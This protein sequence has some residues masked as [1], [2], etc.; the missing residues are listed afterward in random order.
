MLSRP[1]A[2]FWGIFWIDASSNQNAEAGF[3]YLGGLVKKN[4]T[5]E[6]GKHWLSN[7][8]KPW[9]LVIDNADDPEMDVSQYFPSGGRG[10]ILITTRN[11]NNVVHS[12]IGDINF[13]EM[14]QED[15]IT[16]LLKAA[17]QPDHTDLQ[18]REIARPIA[19][20][21]GHLALALTHAGA[22][23][24]R[25]I[26]TLEGYLPEYY[27][28][29]KEM[30]KH[31]ILR[32]ADSYKLNIVTTWEV[33]YERIKQ[34]NTT[35][36]M[37][38]IEILH[39][40]AFLHFEQ[41]PMI[42]FQK[43]WSNTRNPYASLPSKPGFFRVIWPAIADTK[44]P[45]LPAILRQSGPVWDQ[46]RFNEALNQLSDYSLI[47]RDD[48]KKLCSM[49]PVVHAWAR[50]RLRPDEQRHWL[51]AAAATLANSIT[52]ELECSGRAYR[53]SLIPHVDSCLQGKN[54]E[55]LGYHKDNVQASNAI[56]FASLYAENGHWVIARG[57]QRKVLQLWKESLGPDHPETLR[58][59]AALGQTCWN[60]SQMKE[61][62]EV[63]SNVYSTRERTL[64]MANPET[65]KA[66][67]DL[68]GTYW[69]VGE[70]KKSQDLA[71]QAMDGLRKALGPVDSATLTAMQ[72]LGRIYLHLGQPS[73]AQTL[74]SQVLSSRQRFFGAKHPDTLITMTDLAMAYLALNRL[75]EAER[76]TTET[77]KTRADTLGKEHPYT[78]W[79]SNDL[80]KIYCA[81][82]RTAEAIKFLESILPIAHR[83]L[84]PTHIGMSMTKFNLARAY[85]SQ[86]CWSNAER[87]LQEQLEILENSKHPDWVHSMAELGKVFWRG[88]RDLENA[89]RCYV[90][91][92]EVVV[93]TRA[94]GTEHPTVK[95]IVGGLSE[96]YKE[97]GR[98]EEIRELEAKIALLNVS[99]N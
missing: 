26:Y 28:H 94:L 48:K 93:E 14:E 67:N 82:Q 90:E 41:I 52:P 73:E 83:T 51:A 50:D 36:A 49:H 70:R 9:L 54:A 11:P 40:F 43:A 8:L 6:A 55:L 65:L 31:D 53:R 42:M 30:M 29:R 15:A 66:M 45:P 25:N 60:L 75:P 69:L 10:H 79:S 47:D 97:Q 44:E 46:S 17:N 81:Q 56:K 86:K 77:L 3:A 87:T 92:L 33:P 98:V 59:M 88:K 57:I 4:E 39:I 35:I 13:R 19:N 61:A 34:R 89:E 32:N 7:R 84:G 63:Q 72:T 2:S 96:V 68:A 22:T 99:P 27:E 20:A 91:A 95:D 16:L 85:I 64:G 80:A 37:D 12:T 76:L 21:L 78:L 5:F 23:I 74:L 71:S 58:I 24:R 38:A 1:L 18:Q 62:L